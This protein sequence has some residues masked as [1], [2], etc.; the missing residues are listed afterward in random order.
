MKKL[1]ALLLAVL[2]LT[3]CTAD[4]E[5]DIA[6]NLETFRDVFTEETE[7]GETI[8][9]YIPPEDSASVTGIIA[10]DFTIQD[11]KYYFELKHAFGIGGGV[12]ML[13]Y[14]DV[15]TGNYGIVCQDHLCPHTSP[16]VCKYADLSY[17]CFTDKPGVYYAVRMDIPMYLCRVDLN[18][19][20]V[21]NIHELDF[22]GWDM[23][24]YSDG[25]MYFYESEY[26]TVDQKT[27]CIPHIFYVDDNTREIIEIEQPSG[28]WIY[29][30][31][32][33]RFVWNGNFYVFTDKKIV[34]TTPTYDNPEVI[35]DLGMEI[36]QWYMDTGTGELYFSCTN[37][38]TLTGSVYVVKDGIEPEKV[39]LPH[40]NIY[41]F[42][43]NADRIYYTVYDPVFMGISGQSFFKKEGEEDRKSY[44]YTGGKLY[45]VDR[46]N[47]SVAEEMVY[48]VNGIPLDKALRLES[49]VVVGDYLYVDEINVLREVR[50]GQEYVS[51]DY[52]RDVS[53]IRVGL[54]DGSFTRIS[55]D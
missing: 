26:M 14:A 51:F 49:S 1:T 15:A 53:K 52:A 39:N 9:P 19:D 4:T 38:N 13:A 22:F 21:E 8:L 23:L 11:G 3:S 32:S 34:K 35:A 54:K 40:E 18:K 48:E 25:R 17:H 47:P 28:D 30:N 6:E 12:R 33:P 44:D 20:I 45:A 41:T 43:L 36:E 50:N 10:Q 55:F 42:T 24:G 5:I 2:A 16:K 31:T 27:T 29:T 7:A 46:D 37:P